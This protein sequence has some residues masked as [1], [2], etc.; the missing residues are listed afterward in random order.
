MIVGENR[1]KTKKPRILFYDIETTPLLAYIWRPGKQFV[2]H[3]QLAEDAEKGRWVTTRI[4]CIAYAWNDGSKVKLLH[5]DYKKQ[6]DTKLIKEFDKIV[7]SADIVI[8]KNNTSFDNKHVNTRRLLNGVAPY[9]EWVQQTDDLETQL[10]RNFNFASYSLDYVAKAL[11]GEGKLKMEMSDWIDIM[12]K[13]SIKSFKKMCKYCMIDVDRTRRV[14]N[15]VE[16]HIS[17]K[18]NMAGWDSPVDGIGCKMC[19]STN[20]RPNGTRYAAN[21]NRYQQWGCRD[22]HRYAGK[23][24]INIKTGKLGRTRN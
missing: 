12:F 19:G 8:G 23:S 10:R 3:G 15:K 11:L 4:I 21:G 7:K 5:W 16:S 20:L 14:W 24:V 18:F 9:P 17:P 22:C 1:L 13:K 6:N 2:G